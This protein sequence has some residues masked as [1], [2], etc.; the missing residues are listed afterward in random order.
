MPW[1]SGNLDKKPETVGMP[2]I[3]EA[4]AANMP[5]S[6]DDSRKRKRSTSD[7]AGP[8]QADT[9]RVRSDAA[10]SQRPDQ[11]LSEGADNPSAVCLQ[12]K[13]S[14]LLCPVA[15]AGSTSV[16]QAI[17]HQV[18]LEILYKHRELRLIEQELA[19]CQ[20]ALEQLR[21]CESIPYPGALQPSLNVTSGTGPAIEATASMTQPESP[22]PWGVVDGPYTR[23]YATW[24]LPDAKFD[25]A[26]VAHGPLP[27]PDTSTS[28]RSATRNSISIAPVNT[29]QR[30]ASRDSWYG[31]ISLPNSAVPSAMPTPVLTRSK[32]GPLVIKRLSDNMPV[33]LICCRCHRHNFCSVQGFL[34]HCRIGHKLDYKSH[35]AAAQSCG[36]LLGPDELHLAEQI[37]STGSSQHYRMPNPGPPMPAPP[38][39]KEA[40]IA[41]PGIHWLNST[42]TSNRTWKKRSKPALSKSKSSDQ[43][44]HPQ[45]TPASTAFQSAPYAASSA[46]PHL[47]AHFERHKLGGD[48]QSLAASAK[49]RPSIES[50][51]EQD[52]DDFS[53]VTSPTKLNPEKA[54]SRK[55][56]RQP[57]AQ[58]GLQLTSFASSRTSDSS[59]SQ[60]M[61]IVELSPHTADSN[62]GLVSDHDDDLVSEP[63]ELAG[64]AGASKPGQRLDLGQACGENEEAMQI[65]VQVDDNMDEHGVLLRRRDMM[66]NDQHG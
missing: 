10:S 8:S 9:K 22:A 32:G 1:S 15:A 43:V 51:G 47:S 28:V 52:E 58:R 27:Y 55:G 34:N 21:R 62:P 57:M 44:A 18:N 12:A 49:E 24:L 39:K 20:V 46:A 37:Q 65:D 59:R 36:Q 13:G 14:A 54:E 53:Q 26:P 3:A 2:E 16:Q 33:K 5:S 40:S 35:E 29:R 56:F 50:D 30:R 61:D 45:Q 63:E 6:K 41:A 4:N 31:S 60:S 7:V 38:P 66:M 23:H 25:S 42:S 64:P 19:K 17:Q 48:L 11:P